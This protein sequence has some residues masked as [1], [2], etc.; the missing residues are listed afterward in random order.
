MKALRLVEY[1]TPYQLH[2]IPIPTITPNELLIKIGAA[3]FCHTDYQVYQGVYNSRIPMTPSHEPV[4]T[5]IEVG[6][7]VSPEWKP[8]QRIGML[9]FRHAC[10]SCNGC[11]FA[12]DPLRPDEPDVRFCEKKDMAGMTADGG[13]AE[14]AVA[15]P[16]TCVRLPEG[17]EFEQAA[18]LMC[19]GATVWTGLDRLELK[20]GLPVGVIGIGGL[21]ALALQ[22]AAGLGYK[23]V[24]IDN[25]SEG[26]Q[27]ARELPE[28]LRPGKVVD[29]NNDQAAKEVVEFAG[30]VTEWSLKLL[31]THAVCV[32]LGA[33]A[34]G[35]KFSA[36]DIHFKEL[37][38]RGALVANQRLASHMMKLVAEE[39][40]RSH[41]QTIKLEEGMDLPIRYMDPHLRGRLV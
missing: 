30:V 39:G 36:F 19:A 29:Y 28:H 16:A 27:L 33:P 21:G 5:I 12:R 34:E 32:P 35:F 2:E 11:E 25:R 15:D 38:I 1:N 3:G 26:L 7:K 31:R 10:N 8:G 23:T 20:A 37:T 4:G 14:Y 24:A 41:V 18:P 40:V 6:H 13:F 22:F 17:V 9:N